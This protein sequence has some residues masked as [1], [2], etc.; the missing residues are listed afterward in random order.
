M[1]VRQVLIFQTSFKRH[2]SASVY[3]REK[4]YDEQNWREY[5]LEN[6]ECWWKLSW[7]RLGLKIRNKIRVY[8]AA[9]LLKFYLLHRSWLNS[10]DEYRNHSNL[11][12]RLLLLTFPYLLTQYKSLA[13]VSRSSA[14]QNYYELIYFSLLICVLKIDWKT[15]STCL[16]LD[17]FVK[18]K[19][20]G[21]CFYV[22]NCS[23]YCRFSQIWSTFAMKSG[24]QTVLFCHIWNIPEPK[25]SYSKAIQ[26]WPLT[27]TMLIQ[28]LWRSKIIIKWFE[29][30]IR[31]ISNDF[32]FLVLSSSPFVDVHFCFGIFAF[33]KF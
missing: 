30:N 19:I 12:W 28:Y 4:P 6:R 16:C 21:H 1:M 25:L 27:K 9:V 14:L 11:T 24:N 10:A 18:Q 23:L 13:A 15:F 7:C 32:Y 20:N 22:D 29:R 5:C 31:A 33:A 8:L 3:C 17:F 26:K 2:R